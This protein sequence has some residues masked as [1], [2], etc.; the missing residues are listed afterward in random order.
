MLARVDVAFCFT[1][2]TGRIQQNIPCPQRAASNHHAIFIRARNI[3]YKTLPVTPT[4]LHYSLVIFL[5]M[6]Y[7]FLCI[8]MCLLLVGGYT[9]TTH[10]HDGSD[11][12]ETSNASVEIVSDAQER[13]RLEKLL[14]LLQQLVIVLSALQN[15]TAT[16]VSA[17]DQS[18]EVHEME[19]HHDVHG[20]AS[21]DHVSAL[22]IEV[23]PH[24]GKTHVHVRY[25]E[26]PETMFFI[27]AAISDVDGIVHTVVEK[28]GLTP[29]AVRS[30]LV[31]PH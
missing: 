6:Y 30:A 4:R 9:P 20:D 17:G 12:G 18:V 25:V 23:E 28:T 19:D 31:F 29:E 13:A 27:D 8:V 15:V 5:R 26:Q 21:S 16:Q 10:A 11:H 3:T 1:R 22:V 24:F 7:I 2:I 14:T